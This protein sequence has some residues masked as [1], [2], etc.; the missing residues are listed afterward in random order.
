MDKADHDKA[1]K[2]L[3]EICTMIGCSSLGSTMC[4]DNPQNCSIIRK[5]MRYGQEQK[6]NEVV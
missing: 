2:E 4:R 3:K 5:L 6:N 1:V